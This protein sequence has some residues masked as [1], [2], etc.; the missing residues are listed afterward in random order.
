MLP[1]VHSVII[2]YRGVI[3]LELLQIL[4][5]YFWDIL[6]ILE[7]FEIFRHIEILRTC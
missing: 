4:I 6:E 2:F 5:L 3:V 7:F 1:M